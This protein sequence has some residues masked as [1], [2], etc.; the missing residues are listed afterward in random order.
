MNYTAFCVHGFLFFKDLPLSNTAFIT[1]TSE[2]Q[3]PQLDN[4]IFTKEDANNID[5]DPRTVVGPPLAPFPVS[6][7]RAWAPHTAISG[8]SDTT[9]E[10]TVSHS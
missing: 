7:A 4:L 8:G 10:I 6:L 3:I 5:E 9:L 1:A 2:L